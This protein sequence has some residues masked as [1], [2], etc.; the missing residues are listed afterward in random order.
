MIK[1]FIDKWDKNKKYLVNYF[2]THKQEDYDSYE[3]IVKALFKYVIN[4]DINVDFEKYDL[5]KITI[6]DD[7]SYSGTQIFI[8]HKDDYV[9]SLEEYVYTSNYYG[10]CSGCDTLYSI[11]GYDFDEYPTESQLDQYTT[12]A[13]HLLQ[14]CNYF[15]EE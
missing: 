5:S 13:L 6:I 9:P 14:K 3:K 8:L 7:G 1:D 2:K 15:K 12:L 10:S 4:K 11:S